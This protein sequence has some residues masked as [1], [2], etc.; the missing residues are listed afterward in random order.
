[1]HAC[2]GK[3]IGS[4]GALFYAV[5]WKY[6]RILPITQILVMAQHF[7]NCKFIALVTLTPNEFV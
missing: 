2:Q 7:N 6:Y 3:E 5:A 1:M 4:K